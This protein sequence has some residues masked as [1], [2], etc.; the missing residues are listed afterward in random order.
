MAGQPGQCLRRSGEARRAIEYHEQVLA[1]AREFGDRRGEGAALGNLG[2][3]TTD[4][5][6]VRRAIEFYEQGLGTSHH[7]RLVI[8]MER[9]TASLQYQPG[10]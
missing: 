4:L 5:G 8:V 9:Q 3:P 7:A 6:E 10:A 1:I 2:G